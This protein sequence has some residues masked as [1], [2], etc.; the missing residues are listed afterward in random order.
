M[1]KLPRTVAMLGLA[2]AVSRALGQTYSIDSSK[3]SGGGGAS[4][5][6]QF[7]V[8]GTIGQVDSGAV[9]SGGNFSVAGGFWALVAVQTPGAPFVSIVLTQTNTAVI[10]W[11]SPSTGFI[12]QQCAD[13]GGANWITSADAVND[14]GTNKFVIVS[15]PAGNRFYRLKYP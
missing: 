2:F 9:M 8:S 14:D 11:P 1:N 6:G 15:P 7:R 4:T 12:L 3:I 10:S 5:N 13:L